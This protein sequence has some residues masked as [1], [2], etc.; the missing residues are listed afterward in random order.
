M[1]LDSRI[2]SNESRLIHRKKSTMPL[3]KDD[4]LIALGQDL[5]QQFDTIFGLHPGFRPAHAKGTMLTGTFS[6]SPDAASLTRAPHLT[7][8]STPVTLRFPNS[9]RFPFFPLI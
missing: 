5:L 1:W 6:P 8:D 2:T 7:P 3:P 9:P 4:K